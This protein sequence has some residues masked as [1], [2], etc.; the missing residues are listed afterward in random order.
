[1]VCGGTTAY[2]AAMMMVL[3]RRKR[4]PDCGKRRVAGTQF[5]MKNGQL[6]SRYR[7]GA[8]GAT[9]AQRNDGPLIPTAAWDAGMREAPPVAR[10]LPPGPP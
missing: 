8:C 5:F 1:M 6:E 9:F 3:R 4:C 2:V 7:C 10:A